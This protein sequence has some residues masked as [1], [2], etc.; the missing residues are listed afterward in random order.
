MKKVSIKKTLE[1]IIR[2]N[3]FLE[4][5]LYNGYINLTAL[6]TYLLPTVQKLSGKETT[7]GSITMTLSRIAETI[8]KSKHIRLRPEDMRVRW[9]ITYVTFHK[10]PGLSLALHEISRKLES[11]V[12]SGSQLFSELEGSREITVI[13]T[14]FFAE[15]MSTIQEQFSPKKILHD[16]SAI[17][18]H[19]PP[20][21][22]EE[23]GILYY[24]VKQLN[25]FDV[26]IIE[27]YTTLSEVSILIRKENLSAAMGI[28]G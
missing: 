21:Y 7:V 28:L 5:G 16:L 22:L 4:D 25:Y 15:A 20:E 12:A 17:I 27:L 3:D 9:G 10:T 11:A 23:K 26:N 14:S 8:Q 18:I 13:Y 24:I 6:S 2:N 19:I 1:N